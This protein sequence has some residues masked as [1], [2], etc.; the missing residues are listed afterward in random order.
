[1]SVAVRRNGRQLKGTIKIGF[2]NA[3]MQGLECV[4][5]AS[6]RRYDLGRDKHI[7]ALVAALFAPLTHGFADSV[8]DVDRDQYPACLQPRLPDL[9]LLIAVIL[10]TV[11]VSVSCVEGCFDRLDRDICG[12]LVDTETQHGHLCA[13]ALEGVG[14]L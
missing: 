9:L 13:G 12:T 8:D 4:G 3:V 11:D 6:C 10:C 2:G 1:M 5:L 7:R 14:A